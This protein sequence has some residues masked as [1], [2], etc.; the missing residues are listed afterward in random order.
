MARHYVVSALALLAVV[1]VTS[2]Q[3]ET[4]IN[5]AWAGG[6]QGI[7]DVPIATNVTGGWHMKIDFRYNVHQLDVSIFNKNLW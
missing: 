7:V 5:R 6:M 1:A 3:L 4:G 2:A